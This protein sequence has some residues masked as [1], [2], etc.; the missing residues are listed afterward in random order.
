MTTRSAPSSPVSDPSTGVRLR[1][2]NARVCAFDLTLSAPKSVSV[3]WALGDPDTAAAVVAAHEVAVDAA[4]AYVE[5]RGDPVA[6]AA[7]TASRPSTVT[8]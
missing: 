7:T 8:G 6:G 3:L 2:G 1:R 5:R 4:V